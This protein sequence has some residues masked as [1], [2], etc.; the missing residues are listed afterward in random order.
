MLEKTLEL[1]LLYDF[2]GKL[3]TERQR[4]FHEL[5]YQFDL[6]LGEIAENAGVTRQAV[7]DI[8]QRAEDQL[9]RYEDVLGLA[10]KY[11]QRQEAVEKGLALAAQLG[12]KL[13]DS[14]TKR[15]LVKRLRKLLRNEL[16]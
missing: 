1:T 8:L 9:R 11:K 5:Y 6:S 2:Y 4:Q 10:S 15:A 7:Y 14:T 3:L 16:S 12:E 13:E